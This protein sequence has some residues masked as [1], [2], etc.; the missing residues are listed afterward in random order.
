VIPNRPDG[1]KYTKA[2]LKIDIEGFEPFAFEHAQRLFDRLDIR[3]ILMEW[4]FM[5]N[6]RDLYPCL[7]EKMLTFLSERKFVPYANDIKLEIK[8]K[9]SWPNDIYWMKE[10]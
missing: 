10:S 1:S 2:I 7:I 4:H 9:L 5:K 8:K 3:V 6:N